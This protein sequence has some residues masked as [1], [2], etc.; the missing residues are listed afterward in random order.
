MKHQMIS[1]AESSDLDAICEI[2]NLS[3]ALPWSRESVLAHITADN[4]N[5]FVHKKDGVAVGYIGLIYAL[6][7]GNITNIA[8]RPEFRKT[9]IGGALLRHLLDFAA[10]SGIV[11]LTLEVRR[12]NDAAI[13]LYEKHGFVTV[14]IRTGYYEDNGEDAFVMKLK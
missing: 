5:F 8:V 12:G 14:G 11:H 1:Q 6:D 9:G 2:E 4:A 10:H 7:E 3:F 13:K